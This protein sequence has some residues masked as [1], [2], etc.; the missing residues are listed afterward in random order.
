MKKVVFITGVAG[1]LGSHIAIR[2]LKR[3][4]EVWGVDDFSSSKPKSLHMSY[5]STFDRFNFREAD[6]CQPLK[7]YGTTKYDIIYNFACPASP[8]IYQEI[9]VKTMMTCTTGVENVLN[10]ASKHGSIVVHASTSEIY[11]DP[12]ES[13]QKETHWGNVNSYG[14]RGCYD[15]GK[16]AAESLCYDYLHSH[17]V[18]VRLVRIFNTYGPHMD[19][20]DG[21]VISNFIRQALQE[22]PLTVYGDGQQTR[23][24]CYVDDLVDAIVKM[25]ELTKNPMTPINIGNP[26][27]F[28]VYELASE[29]RKRFVCDIIKAPLPQ[30]DP[31]QRK[32]DIS[33]AR[34]ILGWEPKVELAEGLERTIEHFKK[35]LA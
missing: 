25:G 24:F 20:Y 32:P 23:S 10:V 33:L 7:W 15:N 5:M 14:P 29:V 22:K 1:F 26:N 27:E 18:D 34:D 21:R 8:P 16:R 6:I 13:P 17:G 31:R 12:N 9:P 28:T 11:G 35:V 30:D 4:D 19:P 2:H 3:G